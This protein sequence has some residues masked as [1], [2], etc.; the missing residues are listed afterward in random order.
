MIEKGIL[1]ALVVA[2]LAATPVFSVGQRNDPT[3]NPNPTPMNPQAPQNSNMPLNQPGY[4]TQTGSQSSQTGSMRD[5]LGAPGQTGQQMMDRQFL[6]ATTEAGV[7]D[8]RISELAV[9]KGSPAVKDLAKKMI[10]DHTTINKD[11]GNVAD[12][13]GVRVS[14]KM[15]KEQQGEYD[16]LNGLSGKDF[17]AEYMTYM[18]QS[19]FGDLRSFYRE[20]AASADEDLQQEVLRARRTIHDHLGLIRDTAK[21]EGIT[22]PPPPPRM[23]RPA[24]TASR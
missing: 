1:T 11:L 2:T 9:Q 13:M 5:S 3:L 15:N 7:A 12:A 19:H 10:E 18:Q 16:K 23:P 14:K 4:P 8:I 21:N 24:N 17:D 20:A 6:R 22:L